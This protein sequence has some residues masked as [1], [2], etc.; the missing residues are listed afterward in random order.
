M[1]VY[2]KEMFI[3]THSCLEPCQS[4]S[5]NY[6]AYAVFVFILIL[7]TMLPVGIR[8]SATILSSVLVTRTIR[9][10]HIRME[11]SQNQFTKRK[12][13]NHIRNMSFSTYQEALGS[14]FCNIKIVW[15]NY[16]HTKTPSAIVIMIRW[17][18]YIIWGQYHIFHPS[19]SAAERGNSIIK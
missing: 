11:S 14:E 17:K 6:C 10:I 18:L 2:P 1:S 19:A 7:S 16:I 8:I 3:H 12:N 4:V 15:G 9:P 13:H 5:N